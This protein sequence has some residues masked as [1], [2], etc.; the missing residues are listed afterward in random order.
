MCITQTKWVSPEST[1][2]S[3]GN[4]RTPSSGQ[5]RAA[6][7]ETALQSFLCSRSLLAE[8]QVPAADAWPEPPQPCAA[9]E[10]GAAAARQLPHG[11]HS[12]PSQCTLRVSQL[13][14]QHEPC[15]AMLCSTAQQYSAA[16]QIS[17]AAAEA[18]CA[19]IMREDDWQ[20][21]LPDPAPRPPAP[22]PPCP[23]PSA[24]AASPVAQQEA[25]AAGPAH[26]LAAAAQALPQTQPPARAACT[27][28]AGPCQLLPAAAAEPQS[29]PEA[30]AA[31]NGPAEVC[32]RVL[33]RLTRLPARSSAAHACLHPCGSKDDWQV[34]HFCRRCW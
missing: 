15:S 3:A 9:H 2:C 23:W 11:T 33:E 34:S 1:K 16:P 22:F 12:G 28:Q 27:G 31:G 8:Q 20:Q 5:L 32:E 6:R 24:S 17:A 29:K 7:K 26:V 13:A 19:N 18:H 14:R 4:V 10:L 30:I 25:A 21:A